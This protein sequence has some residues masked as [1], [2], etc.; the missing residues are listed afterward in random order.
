MAK[1]GETLLQTKIQ[2]AIKKKYG[3]WGVK[4]HGGPFQAAGIPD[5]IYCICGLFFAFEVKM[6]GT[7]RVS[8]IQ[9]LTIERIVEQ[10]G[11]LAY[12]VTSVEETLSAIRDGLA[13]ARRMAEERGRV[14]LNR[15]DGRTVLRARDG[16]DLD[17]WRRHRATLREAREA[18]ER[19]ARR[20]ARQSRKLLDQD[21][22]KVRRAS[23]QNVRSVQ[24][25]PRKSRTRS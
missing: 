19:A 7:G 11:G 23:V 13:A 9:R 20:A 15:K 24:A 12:V 17:N 8:E 1:K 10:G 21:A 22:P 6:P 18:R 4:I 14:R 5:L 25:L 3:G 16:E 2:K